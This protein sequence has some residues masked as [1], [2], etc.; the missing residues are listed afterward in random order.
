MKTVGVLALQG[1]HDAHVA[2]LE[3][4]GVAARLCR[5]PQDFA[6]LDGLI[7]PGGESGVQL[8]LIG[9]HGLEGAMRELAARGVPVLATC[10]GLIL[11]AREVSPQQPSFGWLDVAVERNAWG[12]QVDSFEATDDAGARKLVFI[13][14]P[15]V[16]TVGKGVEV[17]ATFRGE[18]VLIRQGAVV[19]AAYHPELAGAA[20]HREIFGG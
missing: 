17:M 10:A 1:G 8:R 6:G 14:A 11:A 4:A 7:L 13:R 3:Q 15:R 16:K 19:G 9:R 18:P 12:R 2:A 5:T 20:L